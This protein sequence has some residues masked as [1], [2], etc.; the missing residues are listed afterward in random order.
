M[1]NWSAKKT[2]GIIVALGMVSGAHALTFANTFLAGTSA[3]VQQG[4]IDAE[5]YWTTRFVD[6]VTVQLTVGSEAL[7]AGILGST[8]IDSIFSTYTGFKT[9]LTGDVTS[10]D[11]LTATTNLQLGPNMNFRT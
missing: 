3:T 11:D 8:N 10:L 4:F 6:P 1:A 9:A 5:A 2:A 7:G